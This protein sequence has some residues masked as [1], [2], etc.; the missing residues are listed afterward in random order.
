MSRHY[1]IDHTH[2]YI[3]KIEL[4]KLYK[5]QPLKLYKIELLNLCKIETLKLYLCYHHHVSRNEEMC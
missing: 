5:M 4:L 2:R 1:P 3:Y